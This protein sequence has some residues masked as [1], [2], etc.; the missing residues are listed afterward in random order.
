MY[1]TVRAIFDMELKLRP[2]TSLLAVVVALT[3]AVFPSAALS[4]STSSA[5]NPPP[6]TTTTPTTTTPAATT[7]TASAPAPPPR[8]KL[9]VL[10]IIVH[11]LTWRGD[12]NGVPRGHTAPARIDVISGGRPV[13]KSYITPN[14]GVPIRLKGIFGVTGGKIIHSFHTNAGGEATYNW[15]DKGSY[16][17]CANM[18]VRGVKQTECLNKMSAK[19]VLGG[20][21]L[22][23]NT[24]FVF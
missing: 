13:W 4:R 17:L 11:I 1:A 21:T 2:L 24:A 5:D 3:L 14:G 22:T 23:D 12:P 19:M 18:V 7:T 15:P 9:G 8:P 20:G 16:Y 10:H 6:T